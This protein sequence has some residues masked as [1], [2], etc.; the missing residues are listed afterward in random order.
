MACENTNRKDGNDYDADSMDDES[1]VHTMSVPTTPYLIPVRLGS[2]SQSVTPAS[3][4]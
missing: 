4:V 3:N 1:I 2:Y